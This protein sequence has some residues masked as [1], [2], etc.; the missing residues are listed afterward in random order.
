MLGD[1]DALFGTGVVTAF[2][3]Q[4]HALRLDQAGT[5]DGK[6]HDAQSK[7]DIPAGHAA[8]QQGTHHAGNGRDLEGLAEGLQYAQKDRLMESP[9]VLLSAECKKPADDLNHYPSPPY[10]PSTSSHRGHDAQEASRG[11]LLHGS[12]R[13]SPHRSCLRPR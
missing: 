1:L 9:A 6:H 4:H 5:D 11:S 8:P 12:C 3:L 13:L 10:G 2:R 7:Q